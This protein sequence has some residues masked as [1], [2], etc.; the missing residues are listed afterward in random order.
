M[1]LAQEFAKLS[2]CFVHGTWHLKLFLYFIRDAALMQSMWQFGLPEGCW[3]NIHVKEDAKRLI[4]LYCSWLLMAV[5]GQGFVPSVHMAKFLK[6]SYC[7]SMDCN[8]PFRWYQQIRFAK[9]I[10][11]FLKPVQTTFL[12]WYYLL[13]ISVQS[14]PSFIWNSFFEVCHS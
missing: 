12:I 10:C 8:M 4:C 14:P 11:L 9:I 3:R 1:L 6:K 7:P 2:W 5:C 13:E